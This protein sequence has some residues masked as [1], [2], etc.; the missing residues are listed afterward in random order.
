MA[1]DARLFQ[2]TL[3]ALAAASITPFAIAQEELSAD[4]LRVAT[5]NV[6]TFSGGLTQD[7]QNVVYGVF[8][9]RCLC[10]DI[11]L[12]QEFTTSSAVSSF[13]NAL[14]SAPGSPGDWAA[15]QLGNS[16]SG[17][18]V[19]MFYRTAKV[20]LLGD[21]VVSQGSGSPNHPR[22]LIRS[23]I[24]LV[25]FPG[26]LGTISLYNTHMKAGTT[27]TDR[28]RRLEEAE[29][30]RDDAATLPAGR[31][32]ILGGDF[33]MR[34]STEDAYAE[35]IRNDGR[36]GRLF[37]PISRPG[38][39]NNSG[40]IRNLHSQDPIGGGG[41]DDRFDQLL[42]SE[43][44]FDGVGLEY[45]GDVGTPFKLYS[46]SD[47]LPWLDP[48]HS[49][50][51]WGNDGSSFNSSLRTTGNTMVGPVIASSLRTLADNGG[52][53][54]VY[55][56][57]AV[58]A[59][60]EATAADGSPLQ[61]FE[62]S[63]PVE[64]GGFVRFDFVVRHLV[65]SELWG[66][67]VADFEYTV[68]ATDGNAFLLPEL[69]TG[70]STFTLSAGESRVHSAFVTVANVGFE[71]APIRIEPTLPGFAPVEFTVVGE[72]VADECLPDIDESGSLDIDDFSAFVTAF[73]A[74]DAKA[75]QNEDGVLDI[76]DFSRFVT[77]FFAGC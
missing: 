45:I 54:P 43:A 27:T 72:A 62:T 42:I 3:P 75:D 8:D 17:I 25:G 40:S 61:A 21:T 13:R 16:P 22:D 48:N 64:P 65:D 47:P 1:W 12:A 41:M 26:E 20:Q 11:I 37:D 67:G 10:P 36:N 24:Q 19:V 53:I 30:L 23:D 31:H 70:E 77:N 46:S 58:P 5:W 39:W 34:S 76:D 33:N 51:T 74:G 6:T 44:L 63:D 71:L 49:Y 59:D 68:T 7:V 38:T 35:L 52:H 56:D 57:L 29:E 69:P 55:F 14:N 9:G 15:G 28:S 66:N 73:F 32:I 4:G 18:D 60:F 2:S 50:R